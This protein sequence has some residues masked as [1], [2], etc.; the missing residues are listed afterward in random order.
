MPVYKIGMDKPLHIALALMNAA[1]AEINA[2]L[3]RLME[4]DLFSSPT[5]IRLGVDTCFNSENPMGPPD[6]MVLTLDYCESGG[7]TEAEVEEHLGPLLKRLGVR[8]VK[9]LRQ[10]DFP[11]D[12]E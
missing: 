5:D 9:I 10:D 3:D 4:A 2:E 12:L 11:M 7:P 8:Y 6:G 1:L